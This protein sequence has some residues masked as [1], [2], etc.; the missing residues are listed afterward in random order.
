MGRNL[1]FCTAA[2]ATG[3]IALTVVPSPASALPPGSY[4]Q[5]CQDFAES[6]AMLSASC[7]TRNGLTKRSSMNAQACRQSR[8]N[9]TNDNGRLICAGR[10]PSGSYQRSCYRGSVLDGILT[11]NCAAPGGKGVVSSLQVGSCAGGDIANING[12]LRCIR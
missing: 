3:A 6:G 12:Y 2:I 10:V 9:I 1:L 7:R 5:T 11:A 4:L 8:G